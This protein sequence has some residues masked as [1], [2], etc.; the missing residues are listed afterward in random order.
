MP[1]RFG[2]KRHVIENPGPVSPIRVRLWFYLGLLAGGVVTRA[3]QPFASEPLARLLIPQ[4]ELPGTRTTTNLAISSI[5]SLRLY[6][7][8]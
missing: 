4:H 5:F 3:V 6:L 8:S 7:Q 1:Y 2:S